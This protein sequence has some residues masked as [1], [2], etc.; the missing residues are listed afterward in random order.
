MI[1][2]SLGKP[3]R[4]YRLLRAQS[5]GGPYV[6][7]G[8]WVRDSV[9]VHEFVDLGADIGGLKNNV[10]YY[11]RLL[12]FDEGAKKLKLD[13]MESNVVNGVNSVSVV[14][15]TEPSNATSPESQGQ[16]SSGI[17][18]DVIPPRLVPTNVTNFNNL[19][20][21]HRLEVSIGAATDGVRYTLPVIIRDSVG[22]T[23]QNAVVDPG[24]WVHG[25][26]EIAGLKKGPMRVSNIFGI[27][28]ADVEFTYRFEQLSDSF[29]IE[30]AVIESAA[31]ADVPV[32]VHDSLN[33][34]GIQT[35][36]PYSVSE[37]EVTVEFTAGGPDTL[38][39][40]IYQ[41]LGVQV[42]DA[43]TGQL[44]VPGTDW[45]MSATGLFAIAGLSVAGRPYRY[46]LTDTL[47]AIEEWE[48][49]HVL[50]MR[51]TKVAF[52]YADRGRGN[53]RQ[54]LSFPW[55]SGHRR[56]TVD[57][58]AGDR[59]RLR[60]RGGVRA[61]FP[62]DAVV[63]MIAGS[64]GRTEVTDQM[65][66]EIRIVPNPYLIHHEAQRGE[67]R[68]Y[69]NYLPEECTIRIYTLALD[70]VKTIEHRGG[71]REEWDLQIEGGQLVASQLLLAHIEAPNGKKT[72]KKFAVVMGE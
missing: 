34:T 39:G 14:P 19:L 23:V 62:R 26:P 30:P 67:P 16:L 69:F 57:F 51:Q 31:G 70:L 8:R 40:R 47:F 12:S 33:V 27:G 61:V 38:S 46:Y 66:E 6:Q 15:T 58:Q 54:G 71:S 59:V 41:Y 5:G 44:L 63:T 48:F 50:T 35:I 4:G 10:R 9:L 32:L 64:P 25:S 55:A 24:L 42:R 49:G 56:G 2:D 36:T 7:I 18:G 37:Q 65:L 21:G 52:D 17:L 45:M 53:G 60:W 1:P 3:F 20:S 11:Y 29:R 72:T 68:L 28:A 22:G 13:P 43:G